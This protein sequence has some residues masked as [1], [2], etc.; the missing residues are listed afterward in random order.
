VV[1]SIVDHPSSK[2]VSMRFQSNNGKLLISPESGY[3]PHLGV[4]VSTM[5]RCRETTI[6][7]VQDLSVVQLDYLFD[8]NDNSIGALLLHLAAIE[9]AYQEITFFD[10]NILDNPERLPKWEVPMELGAP[11]R[12]TIHGHPASYYIEEL[13][14]M[15]DQT[16]ELMRQRDDSWLWQ[17]S[18]WGD[19]VFANNYWQWYHVYEDEINHRGEM[20]WRLS[21]MN[22]AI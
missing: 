14:R 6:L 9:A 4:L 13:T 16:L 21:R 7:L 22:H 12:Q 3:S 18:E 10:R 15:R 2:G 20:S 1:P 19:N 5:Q 11:A 8:E 17:E